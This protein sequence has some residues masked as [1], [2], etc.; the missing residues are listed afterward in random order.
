VAALTDSTGAVTERYRYDAYGKQTIT[1]PT[2]TVLARSS[3]NWNRGFTEYIADG[4]T[5]LLHARARPYSP[6][7]GRFVGRDP[8]NYIDGYLLYSGA[9]SSNGLDPFGLSEQS[10]TFYLRR[11]RGEFADSGQRDLDTLFRQILQEYLRQDPEDDSCWD[12]EDDMEE[13]IESLYEF[14]FSYARY[15]GR[16]G[17]IDSPITWGNNNVHGNGAW[18]GHFFLGA[19]WEGAIELGDTVQNVLESTITSSDDNYQD[20]A[21]AYAGSHLSDLFD[22]WSEGECRRIVN[23]FASGSVSLSELL[24]NSAPANTRAGSLSFQDDFE[25]NLSSTFNN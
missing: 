2:G 16:D 10:A 17:Y 18:P 23:M 5:G 22:T 14:F 3:V 11:L 7:L 20:D 25:S 24:G 19:A 9:F 1:S 13:V 6:M 15:P 21:C 8:L 4:E 12:C